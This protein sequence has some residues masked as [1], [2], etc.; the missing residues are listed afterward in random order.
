MNKNEMDLYYTNSDNVSVNI[1]AAVR[2]MTDKIDLC[3]NRVL[4][5]KPDCTGIDLKDDEWEI[6]PL[7]LI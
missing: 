5:A 3:I 4:K 2:N 7:G 1:S 6:K